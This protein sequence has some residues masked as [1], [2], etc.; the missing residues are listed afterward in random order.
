MNETAGRVKFRMLAQKAILNAMYAGG[1]S[2]TRRYGGLGAIL[3][4]HHVHPERPAGR[5]AP[6]AHLTVHPHFLDRLLDRLTRHFDFVSMDEAVRR[7]C[8]GTNENGRRFLAITLDDGYRDNLQYAVPIFRR[9][10]A[11]YTIFVAPG[12]VEGQASLWWEDL[13]A[14]IAAREHIVMHSP[15]R[16]VPFDL[17][18]PAK[19]RKAF[20]E[21]LAFLTSTVGEAEQRQKVAELAWQ[22]GID[23]KINLAASVMNWREI[24]DL[25]A[26]PLCTIGA[27]TVHHYAVARLEPKQARSELIEGARIIEM[28]TGKRPQHFAFPYGYAAA[29]GPRDFQLAKECGFASAVTTRHGVLQAAHKDHLHALPRISVNGHFQRVRH[30]STLLSGVPALMVNRGRAL[31]VA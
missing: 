24:A 14:I 20:A 13:E 4:L 30:V 27:H 10:K 3:M 1:A 9:H 11:P 28:E 23:P 15:K 29:A 31:N 25:S 19:K 22:V 2:L 5:F 18:T 26:D 21:L 8:A 12:L 17:S 6:N 7:L 16:G